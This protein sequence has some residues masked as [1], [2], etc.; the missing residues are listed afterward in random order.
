MQFLN[1]KKNGPLLPINAWRKSIFFNPK[2]SFYPT[3]TQLFKKK[4]KK[5]TKAAKWNV[6]HTR[7]SEIAFRLKNHLFLIIFMIPSSDTKQF[8]LAALKLL[9]HC[10][11]IYF[12]FFLIMH[13]LRPQHE[14]RVVCFHIGGTKMW[15]WHSKCLNMQIIVIFIY[16]SIFLLL[17][18]FL[19][20][21]RK[22]DIWCLVIITFY[23]WTIYL[24][25]RK[26]MT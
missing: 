1:L 5:K 16:L 7:Q 25:K 11:I 4:K 18:L 14:K 12:F 21:P 8:F 19:I 22:I 17:L 24:I 26:R 9:L 10:G 15:I 20:L 13:N 2:S 6:W 23:H 3:Q